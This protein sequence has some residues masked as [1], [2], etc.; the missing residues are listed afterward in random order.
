MINGI[1]NGAGLLIIRL[2]NSLKSSLLVIFSDW[3]SIGESPVAISVF[4]CPHGKICGS[5]SA[6]FLLRTPVN[7]ERKQGY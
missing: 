7:S 2:I 4:I 3:V 6:T 1:I 5:I